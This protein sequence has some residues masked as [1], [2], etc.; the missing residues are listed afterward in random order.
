MDN[1]VENSKKRFNIIDFLII[2]VVLALVLSI[3]LRYNLADRVGITSRSD[4]VTVSFL[5][6]KVSPTTIDAILPGDVFYIDQNSVLLGTLLTAQRYEAEQYH[7]N[8]D[9][10]MILS[11]TSAYIDIRGEIKASGSMTDSGFML[12]GTTFIAPNKKITVKSK[13]VTCDIIVTSI[14]V[15]HDNKL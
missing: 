4:E 3:A 2:L 10:E 11:Y 5:V 12:N 1:K 13:N 7:E 9:G 6:Q 15:N 8:E 14:T